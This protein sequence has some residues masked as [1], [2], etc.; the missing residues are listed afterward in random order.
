M[1]PSLRP[2]ELGRALDVGAE[3][4]ARA[5][6]DDGAVDVG[7]V[8]LLVDVRGGAPSRVVDVSRGVPLGGGAT[9]GSPPVA[10]VRDALEREPLA[11]A[12]A[13][14]RKA[15]SRIVPMAEP[16][17]ERVKIAVNCAGSMGFPSSCMYAVPCGINICV[18]R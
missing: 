9:A 5:H 1:P 11:A 15:R 16:Q 18:G 2:R 7:A 8:A 4:R 3:P 14:A 6:A 10:G 13:A 12:A 17:I